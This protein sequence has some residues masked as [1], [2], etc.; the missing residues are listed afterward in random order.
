MNFAGAHVETCQE[1]LETARRESCLSTKKADLFNQRVVPPREPSDF[2]TS[3]QDANIVRFL[4]PDSPETIDLMSLL[5]RPASQVMRKTSHSYHLRFKS[6]SHHK[7]T[8]R[9]RLRWIG[10]TSK[11]NPL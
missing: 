10:L 8:P 7:G 3:A 6:L 4:G 1:A 2:S 5:E 9:I 11:I